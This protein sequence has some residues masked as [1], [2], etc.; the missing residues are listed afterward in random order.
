[1]IG[2]NAQMISRDKAIADI[3]FYNQT[4][5]EVHYN[6]FLY[7]TEKAY[8]QKTDSLKRALPDSVDI[9]AFTLMLSHLTSSLNDGHT[10]PALIQAA[11]KNDFRK[12][13][14]F[15]ITLI[16]GNDYKLYLPA[17]PK[18]YQIPTGVE[19]ISVNKINVRD[20]Y[21]KATGYIGG[22]PAYRKAMAVKLLGYYFYLAGIKPP[23]QIQYLYQ[24]Q[25]K[26]VTIAGG[27]ILKDCL[28]L[29][30]PQISGTNYTFKI[31][32]NKVGYLNLISMPDNY[33][34]CSVFFDS[35]FVAA[36]TQNIHTF[37]IDLRQNTGGNAI[38]ADLLISY[39]NTK[40]YAISGGRYWRVSQHYKDLLK[41]R[42]DTANSYLKQAI[43][44][45]IDQRH[46][47]PQDPLFVN[48]TNLFNGKVYLITGPITF[49]SANQLADGVKQYKMATIIGEPTGE[50]T[51]DFG[52]VYKFDLPNSKI[53]MQITTSLDFGADCDAKNNHPVMPDILIR[54]SVADKVSGK[55][56]VMEYILKTV[57]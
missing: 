25:S 14:Y 56:N 28:A 32:D 50:A 10:I 35:C 49:S 55:D 9:K 30:F 48:N 23:Y 57:K 3:E 1:M 34:K 26:T 31:V 11:M 38:I 5:K 19:I 20:F 22:L 24:H 13:I 2:A 37:A 7:I 46:C 16:A 17:Q 8:T 36:K 54:S 47:G 12:N 21:K 39:F 18:Q 51:T 6:P 52:E 27:V 53:T 45:I 40:K 41:L 4:L 44:T 15:P 33:N 29:A 42:G 43:G